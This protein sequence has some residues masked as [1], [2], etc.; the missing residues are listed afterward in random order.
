MY[1]EKTEVAATVSHQSLI[2]DDYSLI[3]F[4]ASFRRILPMMFDLANNIRGKGGAARI[5]ELGT[6]VFSV[7]PDGNE[8]FKDVHGVQIELRYTHESAWA[9]ILRRFINSEPELCEIIKIMLTY[10]VERQ[11][12]PTLSSLPHSSALVSLLISHPS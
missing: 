11:L 8:T 9:A 4:C 6:S 3:D 12:S 5:Y 2:P 7:K 1:D 10:Q